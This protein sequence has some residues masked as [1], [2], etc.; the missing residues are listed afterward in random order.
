LTEALSAREISFTYPGA[1]LPLFRELSLD[2]AEGDL[3]GLIGPNGSGKTTLLRILTGILR[4]ASG[5]V[6]LGG[7]DLERLSPRSRARSLAV[8]PQESRTLF[9]FSVMEVALMGRF[10]HLGLWGMES[11]EDVE[12]AERCLAEV[13]MAGA[14]ARSLNEL[15]SGERQRVYVARALAQQPRVLL[16]DEPTSFLDLKHRLQIYEILARL[17][18]ERGIT[19][20]AISH[21]L[22][23]AARYCRKLHLIR[24][25]RLAASG[26]PAEVITGAVIREVY[27][28]DAE[29]GKDPRTG[30]PFVIPYPAAPQGG[31]S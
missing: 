17:N 27:G 13:E 23:L 20:L 5:R 6:L 8:V 12:V 25:G 15:S 19:V 30:T 9:D 1:S 24:E 4:P 10:A 3:A 26:S 16:L 11:R 31:V 7:E 29:I 18:R 14:A 22:N 2:L 21:D 28:T